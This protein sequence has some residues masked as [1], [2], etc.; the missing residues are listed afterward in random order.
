MT[1]GRSV[2]PHIS[3]STQNPLTLFRGLLVL[4]LFLSSFCSA[5]PPTTTSN[6]EPVIHKIFPAPHRIGEPLNDLPM[7]PIFMQSELVGYAFQSIDFVDLRGFAGKPVNLLIGINED[8][9]FKGVQVLEHHEPMFNHDLEGEMQRF[10]DQYSGLAVNHKVIIDNGAHGHPSDHQNQVANDTAVFDGISKA[11]IS[12]AVINR[13]VL[14]AALHVARSKLDSYRQQQRTIA[15]QD[16]YKPMD[17]R[18][19]L[20]EGLIRNWAISRDTVERATGLN[21]EDYSDPSLDLSQ[22][23]N[24][25][26][27]YYGYLNTPLIGRN[28]LGNEG[29]E[30][31]QNSLAPGEHAFAIM[32]EGFYNYL[33][34]N[35]TTKSE[36]NRVYLEQQ[37][38]RIPL[39]DMNFYRGADSGAI[40]D[41][42]GKDNLHIF[43]VKQQSGLAPN[44]P[45]HVTLNMGLALPNGKVIEARFQ[46]NYQLPGSLFENAGIEEDS[47]DPPVWVGIW[48]SRILD[49]AIL[50]IALLVLS[51]AFIKQNTLSQRATWF[52][53]FRWAYLAFTLFFIGF[54]A[55]GQ[56][57]VINI[58]TLLLETWR[59]F[60]LGFFLLDP[61]IFIL[62]VYTIVSLVLWGRGLFCGWLCPFGALQEMAAWL[63][64][65]LKFRQI[66]V[67]P[68]FNKPLITAKYF[69]L[70]ALV[71]TAFYS[72]DLSEKLAEVE[73]FKTTMTFYFVRAWPFVVYALLLLVLGM[74]IHKFYCRYVCP[75]GAGLAVLGRLR[76]FEWLQRRREC[77][78][79]CQVCRHRCGINAIDR[80]G[81][82]DYNECIQCLECIVI[83]NDKKQCAPA[84]LAAKKAPTEP[85]N[86]VEVSPPPVAAGNG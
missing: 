61:I 17:W 35:S 28:L 38:L 45:M 26:N 68:R 53:K 12:L 47:S 85:L 63:A 57:S 48:E 18:H 32:S 11:T 76:R 4:L 78:T 16:V 56:L 5:T 54:Y 66:R 65:K 71:V 42:P 80:Q 43:K 67:A 19:M 44:Q 27:L 81:K 30:R 75:L 14:S 70:L 3:R 7:W 2:R 6:I 23:D 82:I 8:G 13:T 83:I 69:I 51:V 33:P 86:F 59:G 36:S 22:A 84:M 1:A 31:L 72:P 62:W 20:S 34:N 77:G 49:I 24:D 40:P 21:L 29:F 52:H 55:Q 37:G 10:V 58:T 9:T 15:R 79:P 25:L 50:C 74:F 39:Y 64:E 73:P 46:D 60:D 41:V